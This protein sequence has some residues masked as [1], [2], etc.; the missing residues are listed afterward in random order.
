MGNSK[1]VMSRQRSLTVH[2]HVHGELAEGLRRVRNGDGSSPRAWGTLV[3]FGMNQPFSRFIP[4]CMGNSFP[5]ASAHRARSVHPHVHGELSG[6][7]ATFCGKSG[8]SPRAWGT[9]FYS[10]C[11]SLLHRFIP[12]CMGNSAH[13]S[14]P[15]I[16]PPVHPHVHGELSLPKFSV[17]PVPGSS[18]RAWGTPR[19]CTLPAVY[20]R[21]IPTCMGNSTRRQRSSVSVPVHPHVHGELD[22]LTVLVRSVVGSSPRAW[23][24]PSGGLVGP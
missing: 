21:F 20:R 6:R 18:P 7:G 24:T 4:T 17:K 11:H 8:S 10:F 15:S 5:S 9:R 22:L 2:P 1:I 13:S 3:H 23:G 12:T 19:F 16:A 14:S